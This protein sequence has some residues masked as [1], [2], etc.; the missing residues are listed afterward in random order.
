MM[1][2]CSILFFF[3]WGGGGGLGLNLGLLTGKRVSGL[4]FWSLGFPENLTQVTNDGEPVLPFG[5]QRPR[6]PYA[7]RMLLLRFRV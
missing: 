1:R 4:G 7:T 5:T 2:A 6:L 3:F